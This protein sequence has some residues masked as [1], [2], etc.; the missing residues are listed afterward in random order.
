MPPKMMRTAVYHGPGEIGLDDVEIPE[1]PR[2]FALVETKV[3]GICGSDLH[4]Y[5]GDWE[6]PRLAPGHELSG[7]VTEAGEDVNNVRKGDRVC[8]ECFSHCGRCRFCEVGLYNL[9]EN[10]IYLSQQGLA[11]FAEYSLVPASSLFKLPRNFTFE[12]GALVEPLAVSYRAFWRSGA[13]Y[14]N[15]V[16]IIGAGT[17]GLYC[18]ACAKAASIPE[19]SIVAKYDHQAGMAER[20]GA[21]HVL[22]VSMQD[23]GEVA[24]SIT[25]GLGFDLVIDTVAS[26]KSLQDALEIVGRGG[27]IVLVGGYTKAIEAF[28]RPVVSKELNILGS[29]CYGYTGLTKDFDAAIRLIA[30]GRVDAAAIVTHR[31]SLDEIA[32]AFR[33]AADKKSGSIKI[34]IIQ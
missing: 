24:Y 13:D 30:S 15:S 4:R 21:D 11:G 29:I 10:R 19:T 3:T 26:G 17:I 5:L 33:A 9:C 12:Q 32:E 34:L 31:F 20:L 22:R 18:L 16:A 27:T 2:G 23:L 7:I 14:K 25:N 1:V 28:M 6:Q 8:A